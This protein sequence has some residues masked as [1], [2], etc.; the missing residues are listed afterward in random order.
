VKKWERMTT[1]SRVQS[2]TYFTNKVNKQTN[3]KRNAKGVSNWRLLAAVKYLFPTFTTCLH[4][5]YHKDVSILVKPEDYSF[6][7]TQQAG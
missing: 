7:S 3:K 6:I 2:T 4:W 1:Q 5:Q